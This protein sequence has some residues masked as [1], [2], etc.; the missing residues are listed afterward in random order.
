MS[1]YNSAGDYINRAYSPQYVYNILCQAAVGLSVI[2]AGEE[3]YAI[4]EM[5]LAVV[6]AGEFLT[7]FTPE[8]LRKLCGKNINY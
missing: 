6:T 1:A 8:E 2:D 7:S 5:Q 4:R 3:Q